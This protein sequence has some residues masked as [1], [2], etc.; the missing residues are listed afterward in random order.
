MAKVIEDGL[1]CCCDC[2]MAI[3]NGDYSGMDLSR[4]AEVR[5]GVLALKDRGYPT[6]DCAEDCEGRF[7]WQPCDCCKS[8]LGGNRHPVAILSNY[9]EVV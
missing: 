3:E 1:S 5:A 6:S 8:P 2:I 9:E 4:E 7:S